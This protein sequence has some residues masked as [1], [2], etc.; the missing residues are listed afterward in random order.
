M[1]ADSEVALLQVGVSSLFVEVGDASAV[2]TNLL[3]AEPDGDALRLDLSAGISC[4]GHQPSPVGVGAGPCGLDQWRMCDGLRHLESIGIT[5]RA[6]DQQFDDV[7]HALAV[8]DNLLRERRADILHC[9][10]EGRVVSIDRDSA[11]P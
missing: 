9:G 4:G 5:A 6:L 11:G 10:A 1:N 2:D 3:I 7:C 8:L